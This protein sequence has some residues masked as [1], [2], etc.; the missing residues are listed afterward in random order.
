MYHGHPNVK[1]LEIE[2]GA[3][4]K[5]WLATSKHIPNLT[6]SKS[7]RFSSRIDL[8]IITDEPMIKERELLSET[9]ILDTRTPRARPGQNTRIGITR[10]GIRNRKLDSDELVKEF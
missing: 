4:M 5:Q 10:F 1:I 3:L 2:Y 7:T 6:S 8:S 9:I